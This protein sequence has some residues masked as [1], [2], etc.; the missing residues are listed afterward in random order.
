MRLGSQSAHGQKLRLGNPAVRAAATPPG[1]GGMRL[2]EDPGTAFTLGCEASQKAIHPL[3][4]IGQGDMRNCK[5][6]EPSSAAP[7]SSDRA[8]S[9][10]IQIGPERPSEWQEGAAGL[11]SPG[12]FSPGSLGP[13]VHTEL[14]GRIPLSLFHQDLSFQIHNG[15]QSQRGLGTGVPRHV[16]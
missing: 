2:E 7:L 9:K 5:A 14:L 4:E 6:S 16:Q 1:C 13:R 12:H 11:R 3:C 15:N 8:V 10:S